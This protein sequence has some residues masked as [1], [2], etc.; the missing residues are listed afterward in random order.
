[1]IARYIDAIDASLQVTMYADFR[2]IPP[3]Y[4]DRAG[5]V[6]NLHRPAR[7][8]GHLAIEDSGICSVN[9]RAA[10]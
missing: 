5:D 1:V 3:G 2:P 4:L 10:Q 9:Y 6:G 7:L 8:R